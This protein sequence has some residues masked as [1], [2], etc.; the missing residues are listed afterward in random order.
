M[1]DG[2]LIHEG[3]TRKYHKAY[4]QLCDSPRV[5]RVVGEEIVSAVWK[6]IQK[7]Q[8]NKLLPFLQERGEQYQ[9]ICDWFRSEQIDWRQENVLVDALIQPI[10]VDRRLKT[11]AAEACKEMLSDLRAGERPSKCFITLLGK[12]VWNVY[13]ANFEEKVPLT[14]RHHWDMPHEFVRERLQL[15]R[16]FVQE[17]LTQY[18]EKACQEGTV[19]FRR[20]PRR[21]SHSLPEYTVDT[22]IDDIGA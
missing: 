10:Y 17:R 6:D 21:K 15:V 4:K 16:P 7:D 18:I 14:K 12:Y 8:G 9:Q 20:T 3:L 5:G 22:D 1:P 2:D 13:V 11:L 19:H